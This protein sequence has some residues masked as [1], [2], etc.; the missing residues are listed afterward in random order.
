MIPLW[1]L[2]DELPG[3]LAIIVAVAAA[4]FILS[5]AFEWNRRRDSAGEPD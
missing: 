5:L 2:S 3:R 4:L 1:R